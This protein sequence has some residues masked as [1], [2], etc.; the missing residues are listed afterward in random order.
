MLTRKV[1]EGIHLQGGTILVRPAILR[2][3]PSRTAQQFNCSLGK[4]CAIRRFLYA[5]R[6][7]V[8]IRQVVFVTLPDSVSSSV[9]SQ[10]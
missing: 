4:Y 1:V 5:I 3:Q 8:L 2:S 6:V 9:L 7:H 10:V